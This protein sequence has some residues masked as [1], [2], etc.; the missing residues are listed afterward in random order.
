MVRAS[1][2]GAINFAQFDPRNKF[3]WRR[4]DLIL[5]ELHREDL[6]KVATIQHQHWLGMSVAATTP[7]L[8][9]EARGNAASYMTDIV[10]HYFP[11]MKGE[12]AKIKNPTDSAMEEFRDM[13]GYPGEERYEKMLQEQLDQWKQIG[14]KW[15]KQGLTDEPDLSL[16]RPAQEGAV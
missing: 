11:W 4:L 1:T 2:T 5:A 14:E 16:F 8:R 10:G 13:Y 7:E 3:W 6:K 9:A 12:L 15:K